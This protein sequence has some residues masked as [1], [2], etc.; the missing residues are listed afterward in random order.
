MGVSL[1]GQAVQEVAH[2]VP[3]LHFGTGYRRPSHPLR[4]RNP[5]PSQTHAQASPAILGEKYSIL[6]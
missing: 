1:T 4:R 6:A 5:C 3:P 2:S